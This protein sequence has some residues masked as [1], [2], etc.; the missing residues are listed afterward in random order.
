MEL[1]LTSGFEENV[2][3]G[4]GHRLF[5]DSFGF[6]IIDVFPMATVLLNRS[7]LLDCLLSKMLYSLSLPKSIT[8]VSVIA[9]LSSFLWHK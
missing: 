1:S 3:L 4:N 5:S 2:L 9:V 7:S 8:E 6:L